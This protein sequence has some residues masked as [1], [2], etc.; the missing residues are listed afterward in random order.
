MTQV[1]S[2]SHK[3]VGNDSIPGFS[4]CECG[5]AKSVIRGEARYV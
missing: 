1:I 4:E 3:Y 2:H 5:S